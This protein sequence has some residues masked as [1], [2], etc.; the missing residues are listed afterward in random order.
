MES[1]KAV[2]ILTKMSN[3][4]SHIGLNLLAANKGSPLTADPDIPGELPDNV[5]DAAAVY[6]RVMGA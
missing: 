1:M 5:I 3:E 4:A 6:A 2:A